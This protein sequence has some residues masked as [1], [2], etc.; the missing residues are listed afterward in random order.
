MNRDPVVDEVH[1]VRDKLLE[2]CNGN[3]DELMDRLSKLEGN[4]R[5]RVVSMEQLK[6]EKVP[7]SEA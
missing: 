6:L 4:D 5:E 1:R 2:E 3:L 7:L